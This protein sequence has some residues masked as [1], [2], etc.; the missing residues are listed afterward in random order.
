MKKDEDNCR[1]FFFDFITNEWNKLYGVDRDASSVENSFIQQLMKVSQSGR[2]Y[3]KDEI[4][5]HCGT[6]LVAVSYFTLSCLLSIFN[7]PCS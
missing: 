3:E 7:N 4:L 2:N 1:E 6:M 5:D